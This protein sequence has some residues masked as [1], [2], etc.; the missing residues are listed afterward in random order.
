MVVL[1]RE[2]LNIERGQAKS[3]DGLLHDNALAD[4]FRGDVA[5]ARR[6]RWIGKIITLTRTR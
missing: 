5:Q 2:T 4:L 1:L 3:F 6:H